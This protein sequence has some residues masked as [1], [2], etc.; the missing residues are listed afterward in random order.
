[1]NPENNRAA[2][3]TTNASPHSYNDDLTLVNNN[4]ASDCW[5][6]KS[7]SW[8][9]RSNASRVLQ[10]DSESSWHVY[11]EE[12]QSQGQQVVQHEVSNFSLRNGLSTHHKQIHPT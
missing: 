3:I 5:D 9:I 7:T 6:A 2:V 10:N 1:M 4:L 12:G 11:G 8:T